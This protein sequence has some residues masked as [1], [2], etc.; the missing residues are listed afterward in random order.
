M[1]RSGCEDWTVSLMSLASSIAMTGVGGAPDF[2]ARAAMYPPRAPSRKSTAATTKKPQ[3]YV[4]SGNGIA[5]YASHAKPSR[6]RKRPKIMKIPAT[7]PTTAPLMS[8]VTFW[9]TSTLASSISSCTSSE[10]RSET[11][12]IACAMF[13]VV[14][15]V[16]CCWSVIG[17]AV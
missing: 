13:C 1:V 2:N 15:S 7:I 14:V 11:S 8:L 5:Q 17:P 10:T 16:C 6:S 4:P 9:V 12:W 3:K